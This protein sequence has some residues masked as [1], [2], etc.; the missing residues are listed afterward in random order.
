MNLKHLVTISLISISLSFVMPIAIA[1]TDPFPG[2]AHMGEIPG[3][4]VSSAAGQSQSAWEATDTYKNR[5]VCTSGSGSGVGVG[6]GIYYSYCV[7]TWQPQATIDVEADFRNRQN[8]AVA[9]A[10]LESQQYAAANPGLQKCVTWGPVVHANGVSTASGGVCANVVG[11]KPDGSTQQV[12]P[13]QVA[14]TPTTTDTSTSTS[15][16]TDTSTSTT[17]TPVVTTTQNSIA[18]NKIRAI[19][20]NKSQ[21]TANLNPGTIWCI[22]WTFEN[23]LGQE[24]SYQPIQSNNPFGP[25]AVTVT[26]PT[27]I[28]SKTVQPDGTISTSTSASTIGT[29]NSTTPSTS[30]TRTAT[31]VIKATVDSSTANGGQDFGGT[32]VQV[33]QAVTSMV[34][35]TTTAKAIN[36][37]LQKVSDLSKVTIKSSA[38]LPTAK[39]L[40]IA[41]TSISASICTVS[42][43]KI[44]VKKTGTCKLQY[45]V[46]DSNDNNFL[47]NTNIKVKK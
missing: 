39:D 30:D 41:A 16:A 27:T 43:T 18:L 46:T 20:L 4:R 15:S 29:T 14:T 34:E 25:R 40:D 12:A 32:V 17:T 33:K 36:T 19:A 3:T 22:P 6:G 38:K 44:T 7:K 21:Q 5:P 35:D 45:S 28:A 9:Q 23:Q 26:V 31:V 11:T 42:N 37:V 8:L 24:C 47:I 10:T 1:D 2:V 13:T